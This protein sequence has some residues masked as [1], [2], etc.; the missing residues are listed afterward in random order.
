MGTLQGQTKRH[1]LYDH[2]IATALCTQLGFVVLSALV[3]VAPIA[4]MGI[5]T[6]S[7]T[8]QLATA[9]G[10]ICTALIMQLAYSL[11][12]R[13]QFDGALGLSRE[14]LLLTLPA[15]LLVATNFFDVDLGHPNNPLYAL[16]MALAPGISEEIAFRS[17]PIANWMRLDSSEDALL[18][19][20][21]VTSLYFGFF[22]ALNSL[23]GAALSSTVFQVFYASCLAVL[24]A[25]V[26]L[27]T[28]SILGP[29]LMHTLIDFTSFL[30]MDMTAGG[31]ITDEL[32]IGF[33]FF[34]TIAGSFVVLVAGIYMLRRD[35]RPEIVALWE[36]KWRKHALH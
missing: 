19:S 7:T 3:M 2:K 36:R 23:V 15:L 30:F 35:R 4:I 10:S 27:R 20:V 32:T 26:F 34:F 25:A 8:G 11:K 22:H 18:P 17:I 1:R 16:V 21:L 33:P 9:V 6:K 14:S 29:I 28:G 5:D 12:F 13:R 31:V 24:F